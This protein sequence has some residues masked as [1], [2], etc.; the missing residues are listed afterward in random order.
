MKQSIEKKRF[1]CSKRFCDEFI[2]ELR[3]FYHFDDLSTIHM[4]FTTEGIL[5]AGT[6]QDTKLHKIIYENFDLAH[7]S[8][9]VNAYWKLANEWVARLQDTYDIEEWA[10]QRYPSVRFQLP[11]NVSVF[12]FHRDSNYRHPLGEINHFLSITRSSGSASLHLEENL[13]WEDYKP[14]ELEAGESAI[15]N[16]SIYKHGDNINKENY[17]RVSVDFRAIPL[18]VLDRQDK[19]ESLTRGKILD[20][21][22]YFIRSKE[23]LS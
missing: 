5:K 17:T 22:S 23:L 2:R 7:K 13:G 21:T 8:D 10:V 9:L 1:A 20:C 15:I 4:F 16:T 11:N 6:D 14:L 18:S 19:Q 12:E 3:R